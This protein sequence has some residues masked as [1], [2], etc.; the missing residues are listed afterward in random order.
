MSGHTP[1]GITWSTVRISSTRT[2]VAE[3]M[4]R[5]I[6]S[7][8]SVWLVSGERFNVPLKITRRRSSNRPGAACACALMNVWIASGMG[9]ARPYRGASNDSLKS[10]WSI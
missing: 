1:G 4:A 8:P 5:G 7:R 2:P 10:V 9:M 6:A 3:K